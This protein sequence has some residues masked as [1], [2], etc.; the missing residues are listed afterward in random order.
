MCTVATSI[1][2]AILSS[3]MHQPS[4]AMAVVPIQQITVDVPLSKKSCRNS[5]TMTGR[6]IHLIETLP[7][8][9]LGGSLSCLFVAL[10]Q[11]R[12]FPAGW[13]KAFDKIWHKGL[14]FKLPKTSLP[15]SFMYLL[16]LYLCCR[17]FRVNVNEY[18]PGH[19][20]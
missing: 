9:H 10:L 14:L 6:P 1:V 19:A 12:L 17:I 11:L 2:E 16:Q 13:S 3:T 15:P 20:P 8:I 18:A 7:Q 4:A 5:E